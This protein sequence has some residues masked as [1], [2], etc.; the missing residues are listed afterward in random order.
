MVNLVLLVFNNS[1]LSCHEASPS[2]LVSYYVA[3]Y[4]YQVSSALS[5]FGELP[6]AKNPAKKQ[7]F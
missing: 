1:L 7:H 4:G 5:R 3:F 2:I 6:R